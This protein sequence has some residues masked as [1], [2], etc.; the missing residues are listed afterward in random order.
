MSNRFVGDM[1]FTT[2]SLCGF[3]IH[4]HSGAATCDA[5]TSGIPDD[6][7]RGKKQHTQAVDG[8]NGIVFEV[9]EKYRMIGEALTG[10][11]L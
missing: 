8:D 10:Q 7:L 11:Q 2:K 5:Y 4:K 3:C 9:N 1:D 6:F